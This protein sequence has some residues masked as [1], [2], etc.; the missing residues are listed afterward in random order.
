MVSVSDVRPVGREFD[1]W[2]VG[3][4]PN[5]EGILQDPCPGQ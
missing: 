2:P 4:V 5:K 1:P 3:P